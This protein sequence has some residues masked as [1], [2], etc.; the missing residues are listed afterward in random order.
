MGTNGNEWY[1]TRGEGP[2]LT[3]YWVG[4]CGGSGRDERRME[5]ERRDRD[6]MAERPERQLE[7]P[8]VSSSGQEY[9]IRKRPESSASRPASGERAAWQTRGHV[10]IDLEQRNWNG[11]PASKVVPD[12]IGPRTEK[13]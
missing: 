11:C 5:R 8:S 3:G 7:T 10:M 9:F 6:M 2:K 4:D 13:A 12:H 1:G